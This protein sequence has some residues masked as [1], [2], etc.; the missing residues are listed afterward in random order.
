MEGETRDEK[1]LERPIATHKYMGLIW[2]CIEINCKTYTTSYIYKI[3]HLYIMIV[4]G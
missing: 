4:A 2:T 3:G 1:R